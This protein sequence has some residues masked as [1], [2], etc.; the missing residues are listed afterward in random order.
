M[1]DTQQDRL[2]NPH[3]PGL[4]YARGEHIGSTTDDLRKIRNAWSMVRKRVGEHSLDAVYNFSGLER[5]FEMAADD[6]T[7]ALTDLSDEMK[8]A[9]GREGAPVTYEVTTQGIR[10]FARSV[11]YRDPKY[12]DEAAAR[13]RGHSGLPAPPG[14]LGMPIYDPTARREDARPAFRTPFKR[15]LNGG[16][17]IEPLETVYA[18]DVLEAVT[19]LADL[20]L[21]QG[22]MGQMLVRSS[23]TVYTRVSDGAVVA[24]TRGTGISY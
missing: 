13:A 11:G 5:R 14:F 8:A 6:A 17:E 4:P 19:R 2:G 22:R 10:T 15:M 1:S 7:P 18:G 20:N 9:I 24:K 23:E 16:T 12:Y 3:T 21:K